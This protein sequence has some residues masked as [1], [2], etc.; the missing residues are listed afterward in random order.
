MLEVDQEYFPE[1]LSWQKD[2]FIEHQIKS[3]MR[4]IQSLLPKN[5]PQTPRTFQTY[6]GI[7]ISPSSDDS[8]FTTLE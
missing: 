2:Y 3:K 7:K 1:L 6:N 5:L 4:R 8:S